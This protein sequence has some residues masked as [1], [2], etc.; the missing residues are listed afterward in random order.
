[1]DKQTH[2]VLDLFDQA[3]LEYETNMTG[4]R[5]VDDPAHRHIRDDIKQLS[6]DALVTLLTGLCEQDPMNAARVHKV[7]QA[8]KSA[9]DQARKEEA[10]LLA[11]GHQSS[12]QTVNKGKVAIEHIRKERAPDDAFAF[13]GASHGTGAAAVEGPPLRAGEAVCK[14]CRRRYFRKDNNDP[15]ACAHHEGEPEYSPASGPGE[16]PSEPFWTWP[17]CGQKELDAVHWENPCKVG[18]HAP[19]IARPGPPGVVYSDSESELESESEPESADHESAG[20]EPDND[21]QP[22]SDESMHS[23]QEELS[24]LDLDAMS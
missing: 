10:E 20:D 18:R 24:Q 2:S 4:L 3:D 15:E 14:Y 12:W 13:E 17:C 6:R 8:A 11:G 16:T 22:D 9:G 21:A 19:L 23:I 5:V 1:M 7:L